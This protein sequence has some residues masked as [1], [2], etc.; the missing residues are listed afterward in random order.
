MRAVSKLM[1]AAGAVALCAAP[2]FLASAAP[3]TNKAPVAKPQSGPIDLAVVIDNSIT[4]HADVQLKQVGDFLQTMP[5]GTH[6]AV[7]YADY[8]GVQYAQEFTTD[9]AQ[10][11][12]SIRI[13]SGF[14]NT[15]NGLYDSLST[16]MKKWPTDGN[17]RVV[18]LVSSG[19]DT[20]NGLS[21]TQPDLNMVFQ[22]A[23]SEA[24]KDG[25]TVYAIYASGAGPALQNRELILNGQ[26]CLSQLAD[27]TGG[28]AFFEGMETPVSFTPYLATISRSL[29]VM[30]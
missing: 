3:A 22:H 29:G 30:H 12:K 1:M 28:K 20:D 14:P 26:G 18:L 7:I 23:M 10:A 9:L 4:Q 17:R 24:Q 21:N 11:A 8:G 5:Q 19:I 25:V 13:P 16:V 27:V 2:A 6:V 15:A